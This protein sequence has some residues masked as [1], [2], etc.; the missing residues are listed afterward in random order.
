MAR[1]KDLS[2]FEKDFVVR[3]RTTGASVTITAQP[4]GVSIGAVSTITSAF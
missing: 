2:D 1:G 4:S 3:G